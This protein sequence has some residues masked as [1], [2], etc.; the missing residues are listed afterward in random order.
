[1]LP[2]AWGLL[3]LSLR[4]TPAVLARGIY[5]GYE[6][7]YFWAI[8]QLDVDASGNGPSTWIASGCRGTGPGGSCNFNEFI[9]YITKKNPPRPDFSTSGAIHQINRALYNAGWSAESRDYEAIKIVNSGRRDAASLIKQVATHLQN[10]IWPT[11]NTGTTQQMAA[12]NA[13]KDMA[14]DSVVANR[15]FR[16][17]SWA[18][19][20]IPN[21]Q[22]KGVLYTTGT[23]VV[24]G[25][26]LTYV[27]ISASRRLNARGVWDAEIRSYNTDKD[28]LAHWN[29]IGADWKAENVIQ[30]CT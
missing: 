13:I 29:I 23:V 16:S 27:D 17:D 14:L 20:A 5:G 24:A 1:M 22:N 11:I 28:N 25:R 7:L 19:C 9:Q 18:Y 2:S 26:T 30:G 8:Y 21:L 6:R 4:W 3:L 12:R 10:D 15:Q